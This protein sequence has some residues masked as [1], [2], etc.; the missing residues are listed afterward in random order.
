MLCGSAT[1]SAFEISLENRLFMIEPELTALKLQQA[2]SMWKMIMI[3]VFFVVCSLFPDK[4]G[5]MTGSNTETIKL[6]F[7]NMNEEKSL[8]TLMFFLMLFGALSAN[9]GM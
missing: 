3:C 6:A 4:L 9:L 1:I 2:I 5:M 8:Y 7:K